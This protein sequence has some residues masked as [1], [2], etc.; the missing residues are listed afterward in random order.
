M[1]LFLIIS[2]P[3]LGAAVSDKDK[4]FLEEERGRLEK[5]RERLQEEENRLEDERNSLNELR[6]T[7]NK[8]ERVT[9]S[10]CVFMTREA[11]KR[12]RDGQI[13]Q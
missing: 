9:A 13:E 3:K 6:S 1:C 5:E 2:A 4:Q 11:G 10:L 8:G 12:V 7:L